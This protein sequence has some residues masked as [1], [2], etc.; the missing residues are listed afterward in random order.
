MDT[1]NTSR[2]ARRTLVDL[3]LA[4]GL[5]TNNPVHVDDVG[6][7]LADLVDSGLATQQDDI[8]HITE[9]GLNAPWL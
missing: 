7:D 2:T 3:A 5:N 4:A 9:A 1:N 8:V 6:A